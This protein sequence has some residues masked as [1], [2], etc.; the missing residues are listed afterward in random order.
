VIARDPAV[1]DDG[2]KYRAFI[3]YSHR[4]KNWGDW[5][6][7]ALESYRIPKRLV[8]T[9]GHSGAIPAR[10]FPVFRDR[11]EL[12]S[13]HDLSVS[14]KAALENSAHL[15]VIC[16]PASAT[17][18]WVNEEILE[19]KRL[20]G[21]D[22][23]LA[24]IVDGEPN[25]NV[26]ATECF[27]DAL[28]FKLGA[29]GELGAA[30]AEPI[31]ADARPTGDDR[32]DAKL[33]LI[34]GLLGIGFNAL[35]QREVEAARRRA[36]L[37]GAIAAS[38][39]VLAL[40]ATG[41]GILAYYY[42]LRSTAMAEAAV[43]I[44]AGFVDQV[45]ALGDRQ[46]VSQSA[47]EGFLKESDRQLAA[48]YNDGVRS[49][50][51]QFQR[52]KVLVVFA[53]HYSAT[54][55]T[56]HQAER[57]R[58][59]VDLMQDLVNRFPSNL[60]YQ[61]FLAIAQAKTGD[62]FLALGRFDRAVA[63]YRA[64]VAIMQR[65][66]AA[67]PRNVLWLKTLSRRQSEVGY[68]L[69]A[70]GQL[71]PALAAFTTALE[72]RKR[73]AAAYPKDIDAQSDVFVSEDNIG[74]I[75]Q[76]K[77]QLVPALAAFRADE[78]I[79]RRLSAANPD[80]VLLL[81]GLGVSEIKI[82]DVLAAQGQ[83]RAAIDSYRAALVILHRLAGSDPDNTDWRREI[84]A[85]LLR[86]GDALKARGESDAELNA[87]GEAMTIAQKLA[88]SD[89][90]NILLQRDLYVNQ[91][92]L[93]DVHREQGKLDL[94]LS[95]YRG[96]QPRIQH[97]AAADPA[98][99]AW[100]EDLADCQNEIARLLRMTGLTDQALATYRTA[101]GLIRP[102]AVGASASAQA[103]AVLAVGEDG[104]G[105]VLQA[106]R[107]FSGALAAY[108]SS[109]E[110]RGRLDT[111]DDPSVLH[112]AAMTRSRAASVEAHLGMATAAADDMLQ[113]EQMLRRAIALSPE[114][115]SLR[116]DLREIAARTVSAR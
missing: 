18:R 90:K 73:T 95:D 30:R 102:R 62:V 28:K 47:I 75:L 76:K 77:G 39:A 43:G 116:K 14:I 11:D 65:L 97:L 54:G 99:G 53:D 80:K 67:D 10:L 68:A 113:C 69:D 2:F 45:V 17:S 58:Q 21:E 16:S 20:R 93:G 103:K 72:L 31:A 27:P 84:S 101:T 64:S 87:Y 6:H 60:E 94:A 41:G 55:D 29:D 36:R 111:A 40:V 57:A 112:D 107:D 24:F 96:A 98:N 104:I 109:L 66:V 59:A 26:A 46:G 83:L 4:D 32:E 9:A 82:G 108:R 19:F 86:V 48:L 114:N 3:S 12:A 78:A 100:L 50:P 79:I 110:I 13:S 70:Q 71:D 25:T 37:Y 44:A 38:M 8:G 74:D 34:A 89:P 51:L 92:R 15:I 91:E 88:A 49:P 105:Q 23:I 56:A 61:S 22:R 5:L 52:G 33:K 1:A 7:K 85:T 42:A 115:L 35:K 63:A 81:H 106:R